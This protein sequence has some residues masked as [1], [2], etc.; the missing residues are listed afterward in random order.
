MRARDTSEKAAA[1]QD[2]LHR[3]MGPEGRFRLAMRMSNL[4]RE[5][6]KAG[7]RDRHPE[8]NEVEVLRELTRIFYGV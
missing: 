7:V 1:I 6:A 3:S 8:Y 4:A 5:F 2:E